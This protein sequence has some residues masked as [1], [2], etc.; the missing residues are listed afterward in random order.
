LLV[1]VLS[2]WLNHV[3]QLRG[4]AML[5]GALFAMHSHVFGEVMD[6]DPDRQS[7]RLT[8]ATVIGAVP[9]KLLISGMLII[10]ALLIYRNYSNL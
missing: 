10:E 6:I 3:S 7:G 8:T 2:S 1:F 5:F 4:P 9:S